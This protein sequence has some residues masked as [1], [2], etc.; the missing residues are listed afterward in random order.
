MISQIEERCNILA[1]KLYA[2]GF[3]D[4]L[5]ASPEVSL[6]EYGILRNPKTTETLITY[7]LS[8]SLE[9]FGEPKFA[10]LHITKAEIIDQLLDVEDGFFDYIDT[11]RADAIR[12]VENDSF[13]AHYINALNG[14]CGAFQ[15]DL[16]YSLL[17]IEMRL[18][19]AKKN[20]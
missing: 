1:Q 6:F 10:I 9:I 13:G 14:Y 12:E 17:N 3:T 7:S 16:E 2:A 15:Y 19:G 8:Q 18:K 20:D 11:T 4:G 5:D